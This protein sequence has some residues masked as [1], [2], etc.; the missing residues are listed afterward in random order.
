MWQ[1]S[2]KMYQFWI[3]INMVRKYWTDI[4]IQKFSKKL[5]P[6][7]QLFSVIYKLS[8]NSKHQ[9]QKLWLLYFFTII[10]YILSPRIAKILTSKSFFYCQNWA[11][12]L[13]MPNNDHLSVSTTIRWS[14]FQI[15]RD[16][17]LPLSNDQKSTVTTNKEVLFI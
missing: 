8:P 14:S 5:H 4:P 10:K 17:K 12:K 16:K 9:I 13:P 2:D 3:L 6:S 15:S 7:F 11:K 1:I